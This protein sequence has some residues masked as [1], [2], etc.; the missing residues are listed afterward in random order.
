M[1]EQ[2]IGGDKMGDAGINYLW[3]CASDNTNESPVPSGHWPDNAGLN[4]FS[5]YEV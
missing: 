1:W 4:E 2:L 5:I 3:N